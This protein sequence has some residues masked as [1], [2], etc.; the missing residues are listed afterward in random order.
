MRRQMVTTMWNNEWNKLRVAFSRCR[1]F[2]ALF[3]TPGARFSKAPEG[4]RARKAIFR[5]S[6]SKNG[7]VYTLET[8]CMKGAFLHL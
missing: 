3:M 8:S 6:V 7:E 5:S 2:G 4:I 1:C